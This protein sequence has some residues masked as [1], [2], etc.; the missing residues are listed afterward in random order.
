MKKRTSPKRFKSFKE[1]KTVYKNN[2]FACEPSF[3]VQTKQAGNDIS[4]VEQHGMDMEEEKKI[5]LRAMEGVAPISKNKHVG[6]LYGKDLYGYDEA[7]SNDDSNP[8]ILIQ[9]K[10]L[11]DEGK[12]F[13][14]SATP[15]YYQGAGYNVHP[16]IM[17][18]L[19]KG[20]FSIQDYIDLHGFT[21]AYAEE[22]LERFLKKSI[23][24]GKRA[25]L[26]VHGRGLSSRNEPVLKNR[27]I[28]KLSVGKWR[29]WVI[30]YTSAERYDGGTGATYVLLRK[31]PVP[32]RIRKTTAYCS[33]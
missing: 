14:I 9:M 26:I 10:Q 5:F 4:I 8:D 28:E 6:G 25:V 12:G 27:V 15:E 1:L 29:K 22:T 33:L 24:D 3:P 19:H 17:T 30:A 21:L 20:E 11:I 31:H 18:R 23:R 7:D 13:S 2:S 32:R 16:E